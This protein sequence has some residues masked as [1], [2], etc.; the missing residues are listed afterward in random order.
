MLTFT[1]G[2]KHKIS[3][4]VINTTVSS[5]EGAVFGGNALSMRETKRTMLQLSREEFEKES[6]LFFEPP[7]Q[8]T[9]ERAVKRAGIQVND[10]SY[11]LWHA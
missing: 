1:R 2:R 11:G 8:R 6:K 10:V 9:I 5:V 4:S 7:K 3:S